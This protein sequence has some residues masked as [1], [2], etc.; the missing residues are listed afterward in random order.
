MDNYFT[1]MKLVDHLQ[2]F[3]HDVTGTIRDSYLQNVLLLEKKGLKKLRRGSHDQVSD[4][5]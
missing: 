4:V 1:S 3:G 5:A 2:N